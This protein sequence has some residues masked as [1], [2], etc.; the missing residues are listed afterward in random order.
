MAICSFPKLQ[1]TGA[2]TRPDAN[3]DY[4]PADTVIISGVTFTRYTKDGLLSFPRLTPRFTNLTNVP[5]AWMLV[6]IQNDI[7]E[8][9]YIGQVM[10][11]PSF[12]PNCP[13]T[14]TGYSFPQITVTGLLVANT[15]GLPANVVNLIASRHGTVTRYLR[16]RN[17][18][19]I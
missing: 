17:Q 6:T 11:S 1:V 18:G 8:N 3:G 12:L 14:G 4:I 19:Q 5:I 2:I 16:L 15:Y 10:P 9:S 7:Q 13:V